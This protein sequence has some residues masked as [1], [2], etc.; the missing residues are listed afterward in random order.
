MAVCL[1]LSSGMKAQ[2]GSDDRFIMKSEMSKMAIGE[3]NDNYYDFNYALIVA[4]PHTPVLIS[5]DTKTKH[6]KIEMSHPDN[7]QLTII[8][9]DMHNQKILSHDCKCKARV[10]LG[11]NKIKCDTFKVSIYHIEG[12]FLLTSQE[13]RKR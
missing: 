12:G 13:I 4:R 3:F 7:D 5:A 6:L 9:S 11:L 1:F 2:I 8:V 10:K